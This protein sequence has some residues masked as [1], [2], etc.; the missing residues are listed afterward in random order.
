MLSSTNIKH[1]VK[2]MGKNSFQ[3]I[4]A[5]ALNLQQEQATTNKQIIDA[6][7]IYALLIASFRFF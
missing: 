1:W 4:F 6:D 7:Y 3:L 2:K 5:L